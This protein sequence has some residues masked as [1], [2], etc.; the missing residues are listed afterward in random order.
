MS[1]KEPKE[2]PKAKL[3]PSDLDVLTYG[4]CHSPCFAVPSQR[5]L[6]SFLHPLPG[7]RCPLPRQ[8]MVSI[9]SQTTE[10]TTH[11]SIITHQV[12]FQHVP[13]LS[14]HF[15]F[16]INISDWV[17]KTRTQRELGWAAVFLDGVEC[18]SHSGWEDRGSDLCAN[19]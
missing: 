1:G 7:P 2:F 12:K 19:T 10:I 14:S 9:R 4:L 5:V 18:L 15:F 13:S 8:V 17:Q 11:L 6:A 16:L 3:C